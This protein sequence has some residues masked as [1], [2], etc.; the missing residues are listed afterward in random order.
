MCMSHHYN[1]NRQIVQQKLELRKEQRVEAAQEAADLRFYEAINTHSKTH[2]KEIADAQ[3]T[4]R[5]HAAEKAARARK[6]KAYRERENRLWSKFLQTTFGSL[7]I[8]VVL[9][10]IGIDGTLPLW[11]AIPLV[12]VAC[13]YSI[14][15][16]I[17]YIKRKGAKA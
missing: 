4:Q 2:L 12:S 5:R 7:M 15:C 11:V 9:T 3:A 1:R 10:K 17:G 13:L 8:A 14:H 16:F 6:K